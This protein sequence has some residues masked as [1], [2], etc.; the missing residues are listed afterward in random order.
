MSYEA[1]KENLLTI[2]T[3]ATSISFI[4]AMHI[5]DVQELVKSTTQVIVA[6]CSVII[7]Y[8][9]YKDRKHNKKN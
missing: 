4:E 9:Q 5:I 2:I 1:T 7:M 8:L 3:S 6:G